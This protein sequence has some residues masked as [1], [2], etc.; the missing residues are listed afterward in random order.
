MCGR[1]RHLKL[2]PSLY[3]HMLCGASPN[4]QDLLMCIR[5]MGVLCALM[6]RGY[7]LA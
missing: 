1:P 5:R 4:G 2:A 3:T 7:T 6:R